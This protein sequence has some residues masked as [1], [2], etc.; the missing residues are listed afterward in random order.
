VSDVAPAF[1]ELTNVHVGA[2]FGSRLALARSGEIKPLISVI[3]TEQRRT[4]PWWRRVLG[5]LIPW[6]WLK[7]R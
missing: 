1:R 4:F 2:R 6:S 3:H 5:V 7:A